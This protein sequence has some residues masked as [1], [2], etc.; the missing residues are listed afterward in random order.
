M[1]AVQLKG[2]AR[3]EAHTRSWCQGVPLREI[4]LIEGRVVVGIAVRI[5]AVAMCVGGRMGMQQIGS[6][7]VHDLDD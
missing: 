6:R 3:Y 7:S 4:I 2:N 1:A 5:A